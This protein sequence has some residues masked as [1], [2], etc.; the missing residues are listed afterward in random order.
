MIIINIQAKYGSRGILDFYGNFQ[1]IRGKL[2]NQ[3]NPDRA[4]A[5]VV[6]RIGG[7]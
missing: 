3:F 5:R 2:T 6:R 4:G 1:G 7:Q